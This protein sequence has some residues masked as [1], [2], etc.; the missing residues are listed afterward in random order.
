MPGVQK[1]FCTST[2]SNAVSP[3]AKLVSRLLVIRSSC[4]FGH[5]RV[6]CDVVSVRI[7]S[8]AATLSGHSPSSWRERPATTASTC[9]NGLTNVSKGDSVSVGAAKVSSAN[10]AMGERRYR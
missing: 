7:A 5:A 10:S 9:S 2:N 6:Q 4:R 3:A 8:S 1:I